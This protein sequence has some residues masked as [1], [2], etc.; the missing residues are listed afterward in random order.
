MK[1]KFRNGSGGQIDR[2]V[3]LNFTFDGKRYRGCEGD[4]LASALLANGVRLLGR[5]FKYHRPRG[6]LTAG[7]D[8][9]NAL[10]ELRGGAR[11]EPNT[12]ATTIELFDGLVANSQNRWPSLSFDLMSI[13]NLFSP[14]LSAGFYYKTF[15][16]PASFWTNVYEHIIR[17]AAGL[18]SAATEA[19]P[20]EYEQCHEHCDVL[21]VGAGPAGI[22]AARAAAA[23]GA[24]VIIADENPTLGGSLNR[25]TYRVD[26]GV[27]WVAPLR[28]SRRGY[29]TCWPTTVP[30][31]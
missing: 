6:L 11:K 14:L 30:Q 1:Q 24:R 5:S 16:W 22:M 31:W 15:M 27:R 20:D 7:S 10:V 8:E 17:R 28:L 9:P 21:V 19:D 25:E 3:T 4:T 13:N 18:G 12:R 29:D 23:T 2:S 26:A